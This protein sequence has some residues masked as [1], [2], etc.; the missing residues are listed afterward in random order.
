MLCPEYELYL[1]SIIIS[2][3]G[4]VRI[5]VTFKMK[6]IRLSLNKNQE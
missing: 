1:R 6:K 5:V 2:Q 3:F 4:N